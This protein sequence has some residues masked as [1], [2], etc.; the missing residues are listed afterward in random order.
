MWTVACLL[1]FRRD[2]RPVEDDSD[3]ARKTNLWKQI[4]VVI[5]QHCFYLYVCRPVSCPIEDDYHTAP[6]D[7]LVVANF[8]GPFIAVF[9]VQFITVVNSEYLKFIYC[10]RYSQ[11]AYNRYLLFSTLIS[12]F[13]CDLSHW[14]DWCTNFRAW[15]NFWL[16][17]Y[18]VLQK[19][20]LLANA[21]L[22]KNYK[23]KKK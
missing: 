3:K 22:S 9:I 8:V 21:F 20:P 15:V 19:I 12:C 11:S 10:Y 23:K 17:I 4:G 16:L 14:R 1:A 2:S 18:T 5:V 6:L 7:Q 13:K